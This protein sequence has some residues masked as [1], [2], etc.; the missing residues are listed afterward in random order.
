MTENNGGRAGLTTDA[1]SPETRH[2]DEVPPEPTTDQG[3][4]TGFADFPH[5]RRQSQVV[6]R[7]PMRQLLKDVHSVIAAVERGERVQITS[8]GKV[9][10]VAVAPDT[11]EQTLDELAA[12]GDIPA[13]WRNQQAVFHR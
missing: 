3:Q 5:Q 13:D 7:I 4:A 2:G 8:R 11:D 10:L 12:E 6:T 1:R 9:V